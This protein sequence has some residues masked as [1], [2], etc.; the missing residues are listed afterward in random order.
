MIDDG[1]DEEVD[2][3]CNAYDDAYNAGYNAAKAD[4]G[5]SVP[6]T[7]KKLPK[8]DKLGRFSK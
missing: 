2:A 8:R 3:P 7:A 4:L 6:K 5:M 1:Y